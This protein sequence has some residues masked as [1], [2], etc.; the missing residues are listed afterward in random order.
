M[1]KDN[2][3]AV[4]L[5]V[6][7]KNAV[8][9]INKATDAVES[10]GKELKTISGLTKS[11]FNASAIVGLV[12]G[13]IS[14][15]N[16]MINASKRQTDY[17]ESLNLM[18]TAYGN[19]T[20]SGRKLI[21]T[22]SETIGLD[23]SGLTKTLGTY[24]QISS[25]LGL[26][27]KEADRFSENLL[28][29]TQ[30][31][32]S[33]YNLTFEEASS[34]MISAIT[35]QS[36][37]VKVLGADI[38]DAGLQ[39]TALNLGIER[40]TS[41][42]T[43]AEKAIL[44]YITLNR[45]LANAQ[46]DTAKTIN[47]VANQTKIFKEQLA[48]AARQIGGIFIPVLKA[49][50]P[51]LNGILMAFNTVVGTILG[52]FG[53]DAKTI[54]ADFGKSVGDI[55]LG[56]DDIGASAGKASKAAKEALKELRGFDKLN[57]IKTPE[58]SGSVGSRGGVS[59][60]AGGIDKDLLDALDQTDWSLG[61]ISQKA[62]DIRDKILKLLGFHKELNKETG[63]WE[64]K[65]DGIKTTLK[66]LYRKFMDLNPK[67]QIFVGLI[68][69][70]AGLKIYKG[71][72][73]LVDIFGH[74]GFGKAIKT[75]LGSFKSLRDSIKVFTK[76]GGSIANGIDFWSSS[77]SGVER[78]S[79][80]LIGAG[81][82]IGGF[83]LVKDAAK[84]VAEEGWNIASAFEG[85]GGILASVFGGALLGG[86]VG[87]SAGAAVGAV[88]GLTTSLTAVFVGIGDALT[89]TEQQL[90]ELHDRNME[91]QEEWAQAERDRVQA[92]E[93]NTAEMNYYQS[94]YDELT[95]IVDE[96]GKIKKG[97]EERAQ[98]IVNQLNKALG[99][100]IQI[101]DGQIQGYKDLGKEIDA[102][103]EKKKAEAQINA[104]TEEYEI[105]I[106]NI[107]KAEQD[108][109]KT[110]DIS[111]K[112]TK[113]YYNQ[114]KKGLEEWADK[115]GV[116]GE[117]ITNILKDIEE[118]GST[119]WDAWHDNMQGLDSDTQR[120]LKDVY[121]SLDE[122]RGEL[123]D[124]NVELIQSQMVYEKY[125]GA[126]ETYTKMITLA[127]QG[128]YEAINKYMELER[129]AYGKTA[130]EQVKYYEN[131]IRVQKKGLEDLE[132]NRKNMSEE[133]YNSQKDHYNDMIDLLTTKLNEQKIAAIDGVEDINDEVVQIFYDMGTTSVDNFMKT[134]G[135][136]PEEVQKEV[137]DK[138]YDK[139]Y[140]ITDELQ[141]GLDS[142]GLS[143]TVT[144]DADTSSASS[145]IKS[146]ISPNSS[147]GQ[148]FAKAGITLKAEGGFL[149]EGQL[150]IAR[151]RG[152]EMVGSINGK[153]AVANNDQIVESI[154]IGV[155]R[156]MSGANKNTN[157]TIVAEGDTR[158]LLDFINFKQKEKDRQYGL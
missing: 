96:N 121:D 90:K 144:V 35:G 24:R 117:R 143:K 132:K 113:E 124:A 6:E 71:I 48:I 88:V 60:G 52:F 130:E 19:V 33:L 77:M 148:L 21:D 98:V 28:K 8:D 26:A 43:Q 108:Y 78:L 106:K 135:T 14:L 25:A 37:A 94:L 72:K 81:G 101:V 69:G 115:Y 53:I 82:L 29:M 127:E 13:V 104:M 150:F 67:A 131:K 152:P 44:R 38:T 42:M 147:L 31:V 112:K 4:K 54:A 76:A 66:N 20:N 18:D 32:S 122:V 107:D 109:G 89:D 65:Y 120:A 123:G 153:T 22:M 49:I 149:K 155:A 46:G 126:I 62:Q 79:N 100:N 137:V 27:N 125:A 102:V 119:T 142:M 3:I 93:E 84:D 87:G 41:D 128:K 23:Q 74:T 110:L 157:V 111:Q 10:Y 86:S 151:E 64:W 7:A 15:T 92:I 139:G 154:S 141:K 2:N 99:T 136:F 9:N 39:Q 145:K 59:G 11:A 34:K 73:K 114:A 30:D 40:S 138:M 118:T 36:R 133:E 17:I 85:A 80:M 91:R 58:S 156:A 63:E 146:L 1:A 55:S 83:F 45:Q 50:L 70:L 105:A 5:R 51:V 68:T 140:K 16:A 97:Y 129:G 75:T 61:N 12:K 56:F 95:T 103:I 57:V 116:D 134:L 47:E 158:G